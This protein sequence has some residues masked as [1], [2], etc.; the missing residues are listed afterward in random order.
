MKKILVLIMVS[1][2]AIGTYA[3]GR[4]PA[5]FK[6]L[7]KK[8]QTV[9]NNNY[10]QK[11]ILLITSVRTM[12]KHANY[13]L[14]MA[15]GTTFEYND[16]AELLSAAND[17]GVNE[18][19]IPKEVMKYVRKNFPNATISRYA[20]QTFRQTVRLNDKMTVIFNSKGKFLRI[21]D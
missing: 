14:F 17:T 12:P 11:D 4:Q 6:E 9:V 18:V 3:A 13:Q 15:D 21:D 7:P 10:D 8:V 16:K 20:R 5:T 2:F 19:F 1:V